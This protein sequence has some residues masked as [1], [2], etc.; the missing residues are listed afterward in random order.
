[1]GKD[2]GDC[3]EASIMDTKSSS[4]ESDKGKHSSRN[5]EGSVM[6]DAD[7]LVVVLGLDSILLLL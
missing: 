1:M 7:G 3:L 4:D 2:E 5:F 6:T